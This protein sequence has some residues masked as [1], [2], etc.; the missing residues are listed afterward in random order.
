MELPYEYLAYTALGLVGFYFVTRFYGLWVFETITSWVLETFNS[1]ILPNGK[2][3][4]GPKWQFPNGSLIQRFIDGRGAS[5]EW[6]KYG[7]V[8]R[9]WNGPH[10]EMC[11]SRL[12]PYLSPMI[13][14]SCSELIDTY[15]T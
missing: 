15:P 12:Q 10:P 11:V 9:I 6:Q 2:T 13:L 3:V 4:T 14:V 1:G 5:E 8:Y 7:T